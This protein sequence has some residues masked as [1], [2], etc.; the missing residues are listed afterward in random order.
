[1]P[2]VILRAMEPTDIDMMYRLEND[3]AM[4]PTAGTTAPYSR[5][6]LQAY[7]DNTQND[8]FADKQLRMVVEVDGQPA[9]CA[10]LF[11][12]DALSLRAEVGLG[13]LPE[14]RHGGVGQEA[15]KQ[16]IAYAAHMLGLRSL[17]GIVS[18]DN[19]ACMAMMQRAGFE[20]AGR[21]KRWVRTP[22]GYYDAVIW[23]ITIET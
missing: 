9:G 16:L 12:I 8:A 5:H 14:H 1:M 18:A 19:T 15:M 17:M 20:E 21:L 7:I 11:N 10:D 3:R 23:Q 2:Q 4:W 22:N 13:L 6:V